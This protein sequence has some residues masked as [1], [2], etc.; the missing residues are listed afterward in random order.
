M[1]E[2]RQRGWKEFFKL[3]FKSKLPWHLYIFG[4]IATAA[5]TTVGLIMPKYIGN[6][7]GGDIFNNEIV[8]N[9]I[10]LGIL[11]QILIA[12]SA[13]FFSLTPPIAMRNVQKTIWS[14]IM[15]MK[16]R[17]YSKQPS[18]KLISRVTDDPLYI[19]TVV[20]GIKTVLNS[21]YSLVGSYVIMYSM[22]PKLTFALLPVIP[23]IL[24]VS[25]IVGHYTQKT[26]MG[27]QAQYSGI[28]AFFAE[29][30]PRIRMVKSFNKEHEEINLG[31]EILLDQ[32]KAE[33]K[34]IVVDLYAEPLM[35]SVR[36]IIVG[37]TLV[38]GS[39]LISQG[40]LKV[41]QL[42]SF[43]LYVQFIHSN[44]LQYGLFWQTL[45]Q[46]KGASEKIS[47]IL[48]SESERLQRE[49][50]MPSQLAQQDLKL[51]N[52][53][54]GYD[55]RNILSR[56]NIRIPAGKVTA[57][58]GPS[59]CGKSTIFKLLE[60]FYEPNAG[61]LLIGD[62]EAEKVHVDEWRRSIA[63]V[64]Q[65]SPLLSGTI[66]DNI[67]YG[68]ERE[69]SVEELRRAAELAD[70]LDFIEEFPEGFETEVGEFGSRLSGG[71]RQRIAIA[72]AFIQDTSILLLDEATAS[73]DAQSEDKIEKSLKT[74]MTGKTTV[75]IT[76]DMSLIKEADQII[77]IDAG[78]VSGTGTHNEL[79]RSNKLYKILVDIQSSK[80]EG[81]VFS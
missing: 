31:K 40:E 34:R 13:L 62:T 30:L 12:I 52:V 8:R 14:K 32:Y 9:Y 65:T 49:Q 38:Y 60:R 74:L 70:A 43:Y 16:M 22:N 5:S 20:S 53:S 3:V 45:K 63:S 39:Y 67:T 41:S 75:M 76:H 4:I 28:T 6:I 21:T 64:S 56:L 7:F 68:L 55:D 54:F 66:R 78:E 37:T 10:L 27:V 35:Q 36:A 25:A 33:K 18:Q 42:L 81:L 47:S 80:E 71:Q 73:L 44:V 2:T 19:D 1:E 46:A 77:V 59:G 51:E 72:R 79:M 17:D 48:D 57:I 11:S 58:V 23:Y 69:V 26:Q 29:R 50:S 61:R 24:I 15:H